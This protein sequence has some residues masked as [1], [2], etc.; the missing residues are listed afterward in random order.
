MEKDDKTIKKKNKVYPKEIAEL[1]DN[2]SLMD[3][4]LMA[5]VFNENIPATQLLIST[6]LSRDVV[7]ESTKGQFDVKN[8]IVGGRNIRLDIFAREEQGNYFNCEVQ[9]SD[10]GAKPARA[11][12]HSAMLDSRMLE[13]GQ[14]FSEIKDSYVIFITE[15]DYYNSGKALYLV[16]RVVDN[17]KAFQDGNHIIYVN[18]SYEGD[19]NLGRLLQDMRNKTKEGFNYKELEESVRHFKDTSEGREIMSEAVERYAKKYS[20]GQYDKGIIDS[21]KNLMKNLKMTAEQAM[22]AIGVP[23]SERKKYMT[24]L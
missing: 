9:R 10:D 1:I 6:I 20:E 21:I 16:E 3:D 15:K 7:I 22:D 12:F 19:D 4:E 24:M 13:A 14:R 23:Q 2:M 5:R 18:A 17:D 11:R 8:P